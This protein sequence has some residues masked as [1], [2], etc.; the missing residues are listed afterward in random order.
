MENLRRENTN[1]N[2]KNW[3]NN[4]SNSRQSSGSMG[5]LRFA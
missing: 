3:A 4:S 1:S 2:E 5:L